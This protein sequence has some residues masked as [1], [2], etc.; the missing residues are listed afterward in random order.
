MLLFPSAVLSRLVTGEANP[1]V[2]SALAQ[3]VT[4]FY[5]PNEAGKSTLLAFIRAILFGFPRQFRAHYP[6]LSGGRQGGRITVSDNIGQI[7]TIERFVGIN[8]GLTVKAESGLP[9]SEEVLT[10]LL[11]QASTDIFKSVF[12]FSLDE[13][14]NDELLESDGVQKYIYSAGMGAPRVPHLQKFLS[15]RPTL[16]FVS[17]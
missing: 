17:R 1:P 10:G 13:L 3:R 15:D 5:G 11:G 2:V 9:L 7:F 16:L 14:Q 8:G 6:P 4:V 12:A